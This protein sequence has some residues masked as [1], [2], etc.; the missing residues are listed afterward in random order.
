MRRNHHALATCRY[1]CFGRMSGRP[2]SVFFYLFTFCTWLFPTAPL[3]S[4]LSH[5]I[6]FS[7][8]SHSVSFVSPWFSHF[9]STV[10]LCSSSLSSLLSPVPFSPLFCPLLLSSVPFLVLKPHL[11]PLSPSLLCPLMFPLSVVSFPPLSLLFPSFV[12]SRATRLVKIE[13]KSQYQ[14]TQLA[15][16]QFLKYLIFFTNYKISCEFLSQ[17]GSF[18]ILHLYQHVQNWLTLLFNYTFYSAK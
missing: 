9:I 14:R 5:S 6:P 18:C 7:S 13:S 1:F 12:L 3:L 15:R 10:S 2:S 4:L 16:T 11:S 8:L 17:W